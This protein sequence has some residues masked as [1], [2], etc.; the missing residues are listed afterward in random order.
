LEKGLSR[1]CCQNLHC[2]D[3]S[4]GGHGNLAVVGHYGKSRLIRLLYCRTCKSRFS[5]RK[6]TPASPEPP[7]V[8]SE[9]LRVIRLLSP[10][11]A[12]H[13]RNWLGEAPTE[14]VRPMPA[15]I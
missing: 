2:P 8:R 7:L 12:N 6:G 10:P 1:S 5:E 3:L 13:H 4:E 15:E 9:E 11:I 14:G